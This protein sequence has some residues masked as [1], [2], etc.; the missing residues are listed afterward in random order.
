[1]S[2]WLFKAVKLTQVRETVTKKISHVLSARK[3]KGL[4]QRECVEE[5]G[6]ISCLTR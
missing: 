3:Q 5:V 4:Q 6:C 1:M 2:I